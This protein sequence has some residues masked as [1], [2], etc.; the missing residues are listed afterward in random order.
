M[1]N[2]FVARRSFFRF[3]SDRSVAPKLLLEP[4][5]QIAVVMFGQVSDN[6]LSSIRQAFIDQ[7]TCTPLGF[8]VEYW[9]C[10]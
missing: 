2:F 3:L 6:C 9:K 1:S 10:L 7:I 5:L 8:I 4:L